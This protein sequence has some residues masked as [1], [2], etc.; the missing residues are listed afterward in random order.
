MS[1]GDGR[2]FRAWRDTA[3]GIGKYGACHQAFTRDFFVPS[4]DR[5]NKKS[6]LTAFNVALVNNRYFFLLFYLTTK[7]IFLIKVTFYLLFIYFLNEK[8][9]ELH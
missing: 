3:T 8:V 7:W 2:R 5:N 1:R 9:V 6:L 4:L